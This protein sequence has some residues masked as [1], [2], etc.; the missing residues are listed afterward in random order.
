M[1]ARP[2]FGIC[3]VAL[4]CSFTFLHILNNY[5][6]LGLRDRQYCHHAFVFKGLYRQI[7]LEVVY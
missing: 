7:G 1:T 6:V 3:L 4:V 5:D 2:I